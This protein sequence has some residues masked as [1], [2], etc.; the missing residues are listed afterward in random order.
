MPSAVLFLFRVIL[1][2]LFPSSYN[3]ENCPLKIVTTCVGI[4]IGI[5]LKGCWILSKT[6]S[7]SNEMI[8]WFFSFGL[9]I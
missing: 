9:F 5:E 7:A 1:A 3:A 8:V 6:F 4:V 2:L